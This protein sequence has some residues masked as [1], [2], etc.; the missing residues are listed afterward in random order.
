MKVVRA[1]EMATN[2]YPHAL[3]HLVA[4][5]NSAPVTDFIYGAPISG[6]KPAVAGVVPEPLLPKVKYRIFVEAGKIK[7]VRDFEVH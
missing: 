5:T 2:K 3:W 4:E 6:M 1:D 7:G